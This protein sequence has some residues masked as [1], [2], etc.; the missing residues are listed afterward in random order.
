MS[1]EIVLPDYLKE[2]VD[3]SAA[4]MVS[5][6]GGSLP[7][8]SIR[9]RQFRFVIDGTEDFK[10]TEPI[11]V[12]ILGVVPEQ[13]MAKTFYLDGYQP[14]SSDPPNCSSFL[15]VKPDSWVDNPQSDTCVNCDHSKWGSATSMSGK[16]S[17]ACKESKRLIII[18]ADD[19]KG[20]EPIK[21]VFNVTVAS[22][23]ALTNY[24]KFLIAN[25]LPMSAIITNISFADS[26]FPQ[27]EFNFA[28][29]LNEQFGTKA[30]SIAEKREWMDGQIEAP[31]PPPEITCSQESNAKT[32]KAPKT[33]KVSESVSE[34]LD[35]DNWG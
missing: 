16:K 15:G 27:V 34:D 12:V 1:K 13:G 25:R 14:G 30:L 20:K 11:N 2:L 6:S 4:G 35:L 33:S 10:Q 3:N 23:K 17:K 9:G 5:G 21:Y 7:R 26:E 28:S 31:K 22:L 19:L 8:V 24:G 18:K 32:S 29:V